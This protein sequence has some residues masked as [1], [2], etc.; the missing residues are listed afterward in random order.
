MS[1]YTTHIYYFKITLY[2]T[3]LFFCW[4][5][6]SVPLIR[7]AFRVPYSNNVHNKC[8]S[9]NC[10]I[11]WQLCLIYGHYS[12]HFD[13]NVFHTLDQ[14]VFAASAGADESL[15]LWQCFPVQ[16][17]SGKDARESSPLTL[18][19]SVRWQTVK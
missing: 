6:F 19:R 7:I 13:I 15:C 1:V 5:Q 10:L 16:R 3:K 18:G 4:P 8:Q 17:R 2:G 9:K 14:S 12:S 11:S